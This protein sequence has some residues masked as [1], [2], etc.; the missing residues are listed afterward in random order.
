MKTWQR[1]LIVLGLA[2]AV[3][4]MWVVKQSKSEK[5]SSTAE[6]PTAPAAVN[7]P[8]LAKP[9]TTDAGPAVVIPP[10]PKLVDLGAGKC[11]PCKMMAPILED[12]RVNY[13]NQ[14]EV[15]FYDVWENPEPARQFGIRVIPTQIFLAADGRELFRHEGFFAKEDILAKWREFGVNLD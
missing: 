10:K 9:L 12:L 8:S 5:L 4:A 13:S 1:V 2:V 6:A 11:I 14:I 15:V 7:T 3:A